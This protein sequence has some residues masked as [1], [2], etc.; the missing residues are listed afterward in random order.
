MKSSSD[1][2]IRMG[3]NPTL[4]VSLKE[5]RNLGSPLVVQWV[6]RG[7][8]NAGGLG[9]GTRSYMHATAKSLHAATKSPHAT[10]KQPARCNERSRMLQLRPGAAKI[11]K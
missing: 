11:N 6:R 7:A 2:I 1:D 10:T 4:L 9:W 3:P 5:E 8:P